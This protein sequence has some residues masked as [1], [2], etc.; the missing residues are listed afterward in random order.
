MLWKVNGNWGGPNF[1]ATQPPAHTDLIKATSTPIPF[2]PDER[3]SSVPEIM[4]VHTVLIHLKMHII[5]PFTYTG[6]AWTSVNRIRIVYS[7]RWLLMVR[8][9]QHATRA[10]FAGG[11]S[12]YTCVINASRY[13]PAGASDFGRIST[14]IGFCNIASSKYFEFQ[15]LNSSEYYV[16]RVARL[17]EAYNTRFHF[18]F[19]WISL[20]SLQICYLKLCMFALLISLSCQRQKLE[21]AKR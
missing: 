12:V 20:V 15:Y 8:S 7:C 6:H 11:S 5:W 13:S 10:S 18:F 21:K 4:P 17:M 16:I 14:L 19:F 3:F 2:C 9:D 1:T